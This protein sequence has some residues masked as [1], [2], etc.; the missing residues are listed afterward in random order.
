MSSNP[1]I[2]MTLEEA[3][4]EVLALLTGQDLQYDPL[5]DRFQ[6]VARLLN[7][8]LRMVA[9]EH[10]WSYY[11]DEVLVGRTSRGQMEYPLLSSWRP[12][13]T[14][15]DSVRLCQDGLP[16]YWAYFLP[17]DALHKYRYKQDLKVAV[18]RNVLRFSRPPMT[19]ECGLEILMPVMREPKRFQLP[20]PAADP[21]DPQPEIG[22]DVLDALVDF[23]YPDLVV[24]KAT[25]LYSL[26]DPVMQPRAQ[27]LEAHYKDMMY[28]LIER[29]ERKTDTPYQ[30]EFI[31]PVTNSIR[32]TPTGFH[33]HPHSAEW[34]R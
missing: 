29:D 34:P 25:H 16:L 32:D 8:A 18:T 21:Y 30:N 31:L 14:G 9:L 11:S 26:T 17:R 20:A 1:E 22:R 24:A 6:V 19:N 28:S 2:S 13:M 4:A 15:D 10:E 7:R 12:R 23:D 27:T 5:L 3:V 33:G